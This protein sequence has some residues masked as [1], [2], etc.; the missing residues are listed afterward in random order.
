MDSRYSFL[1]VI[2]SIV[3]AAN[4]ASAPFIRKCKWDDS[5]CI[6]E[7]AQ[8]AIPILAA[9]IPELGVEKLDPFYMK[10]LDASSSGLKLLLWDIKG[11]GLNGCVAKKVQRDINKSKLIVK[12]QCSVDFAGK[13]EMSGRLLI[14]PIEGKGDAHVVLRKIVIT[15]EVDIG[16]NIGQDGEKHWKIKNWK[17]TYDLKE[18]STIELENLFNG[19]EVLGRAAR[20]LIASSSNEIVKEV[21]PP[22]VKAIIGKIIANV[23]N[24]FQSVPASEL[25]IE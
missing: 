8:S 3:C 16:D 13:Y 2:L 18:K 21:G 11:T 1:L 24:F 7:S 20:E 22:I 10:S 12:L 15:A 4:A 9:G 6:K 19:N 5:K 23:D 14:L 17:H 25:A